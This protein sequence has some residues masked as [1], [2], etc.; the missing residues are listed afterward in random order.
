MF[1]HCQKAPILYGFQDMHYEFALF[2]DNPNSIFQVENDFEFIISIDNI[3]WDKQ[4]GK[5]SGSLNFF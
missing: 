1:A 4:R 3:L 5:S 2:Y